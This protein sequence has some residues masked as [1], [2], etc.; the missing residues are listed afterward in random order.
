TGFQDV[1]KQY[2][3]GQLT[4]FPLTGEAQGRVPTPQSRK[5]LHDKNPKGFPEGGWFGG[6]NVNL[7][8]GQGETVVTPLQLAN[9]YATFGNGGTVWQPQVAA[10]VLDRTG[11]VVTQ[12]QP[13]Q[14]GHVD[15]PPEVRG[16]ILSG[17]EGAVASPKGTAF[18]AFAGF[19]L[20]QLQVAGQTGTA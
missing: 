5:K 6:D 16:P 13:K 4:N 3:L 12:I 10:R 15:L 14:I 19:P 1:A 17:L 9:A 18:S 20:D 8:I 2:G 11:K 7:A